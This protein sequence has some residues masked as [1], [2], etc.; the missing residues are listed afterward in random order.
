[1]TPEQREKAYTNA[2]ALL[3][4]EYILKRAI[5]AFLKEAGTP[6][7]SLARKVVKEV[8]PDRTEDQ[9]S[10]AIN[11]LQKEWIVL[12]VADKQYSLRIQLNPKLITDPP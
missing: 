8:C 5:V 3:Q 2:L 1:M 6:Q 7:L 4:G 12:M 9:I 10:E 11:V